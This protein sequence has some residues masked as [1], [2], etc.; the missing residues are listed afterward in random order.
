MGYGSA[1]QNFK[2]PYFDHQTFNAQSDFVVSSPKTSSSRFSPISKILGIVALC[3]VI[4]FM[5][6]A[7]MSPSTS[8]SR[9]DAW[10]KT[11]TDLAQVATS[12]LCSGSA[13]AASRATVCSS[14][15]IDCSTWEVQLPC[16]NTVCNSDYYTITIGGATQAL[17]SS[18]SASSA[19]AYSLLPAVYTIS[20]TAYCSPGFYASTD[21]S[22]T[23]IIAFYD[24]TVGLT[25]SGS[26]NPRVELREM[27]STGALAS[28]SLVDGSTNTL[29][30]VQSIQYVAAVHQS[31]TIMQIFDSANG[32]FIEVQSRLSSAGVLGISIIW[33]QDWTSS[34]TETKVTLVPQY[35]LGT[36]YTLKATASSKNNVSSI[37]FSY[38]DYAEVSYTAT[39]SCGCS[40]SDVYFKTGAYGQYASTEAPNDHHLV[41][42]YGAAITH[43]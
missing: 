29:T 28:W 16:S 38:V 43:N 3:A 10:G 11:P 7:I 15:I 31:V 14:G 40:L 25:T 20:G 42:L 12:T 35:V 34:D 37:N 32:A 6:G 1:T 36:K 9:I 27:T 23:P 41:Y 22:G 26:V 18:I 17:L 19:Y 4:A 30:I 33:F 8:E 13:P 39:V 5:G 24:P 21:A 2:N